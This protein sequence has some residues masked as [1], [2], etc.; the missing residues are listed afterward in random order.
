MLLAQAIDQQGIVAGNAVHITDRQSITMMEAPVLVAAKRAR[1]RFRRLV[2][3]Q[4][5]RCLWDVLCLDCGDQRYRIVPLQHEAVTEQELVCAY[6]AMWANAEIYQKSFSAEEASILVGQLESGLVLLDQAGAVCGLV[7]GCL[8]IR[9]QQKG[10]ARLVR[11]PASATYLA[12]WGLIDST[13]TSPYR[14]LGLGSFLLILYL[15]GR[16]AAGQTEV[17][18]ITAEKGYG[19]VQRNPACPLYEAH[20]F[21]VCQDPSG[22]PLRRS[23]SQLRLDGQVGTHTSIYYHA[24]AED[25]KAALA[26]ESAP[27]DGF[28][29]ELASE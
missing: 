4:A 25:I 17:I 22:R 20:G 14:G 12:E 3:V 27:I 13:P 16:V 9:A 21:R 29:F 5:V 11:S 7:G 8:V 15:W 2:A 19:A 1:A 10:I 24:M 28:R 18:L 23:V 26:P 6:Q